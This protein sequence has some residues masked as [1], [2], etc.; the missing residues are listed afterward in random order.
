[1]ARQRRTDIA[2]TRAD[3]KLVL[4][5]KRHYHPEVW[6]AAS[7]QLDRFYARDPESKGFGIYLVLW[8]GAYKP[9]PALGKR[10]QKPQSAKE[11]EVALRERLPADDKKRIACVVLDV[12]E[13]NTSRRITT[14]SRSS[15]RKSRKRNVPGKGHK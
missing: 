2:V 6:S 15:K 13:G 8:F 9:T 1:M 12:S 7:G 11:M 10:E 5:L 3:M 4:E 14:A